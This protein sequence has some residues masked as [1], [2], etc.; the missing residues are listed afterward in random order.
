VDGQA[1]IRADQDASGSVGLRG[2]PPGGR[3]R[4]NARGPDDGP[5]GDLGLADHDA[6]IAAGGD[7]RVEVN[8]DAQ[9]LEPAFGVLRERLGEARQPARASIGQHHAVPAEI[10]M[11]PSPVEDGVTTTEFYYLVLGA[12]GT[13]A[14]GTMIAT[15]RYKDASRATAAVALARTPVARAA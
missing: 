9:L 8:L 2:E 5:C 7:G 1:E 14:A 12:F 6:H 13:F 4:S 10:I 3:R 15:L 11:P